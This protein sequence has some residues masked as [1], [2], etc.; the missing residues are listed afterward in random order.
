M[1]E[2]FTMFTQTK[3]KMFTIDIT[4]KVCLYAVK[5][6]QKTGCK[7]MN[8]VRF[9]KQKAKCALICAGKTQIQ[10]AQ[11]MTLSRPCLSKAMN[12]GS[13]TTNTAKRIAAALDVPLEELVESEA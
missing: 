10:L 4:Q 7:E 11:E 1:E 5:R 2:V 9:N 8:I 12:G 13:V 6:K 3:R